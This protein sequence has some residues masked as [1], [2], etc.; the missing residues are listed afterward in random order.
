MPMNGKQAGGVVDHGGD[1]A[2]VIRLIEQHESRIHSLLFA[3][4][5]NL[6][7]IDSE[8]AALSRLA[9]AAIRGEQQQTVVVDGRVVEDR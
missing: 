2:H 4:K 1:P 7:R 8:V 6:G 5:P 3:S 9:I